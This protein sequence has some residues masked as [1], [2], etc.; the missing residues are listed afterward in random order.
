MQNVRRYAVLA[1]V[2]LLAACGDDKKSGT[3]PD[4]D[5]LDGTFSATLSGDI[6]GALSGV[7][8]HAAVSSGEDQGFVMAFE[9]TPTAG[10]PTAS[11][12]IARENPAMPATGQITLK[13]PE[14][15]TFGPN[16]YAMLAVVTD[17][18]GH[19]W[20]CGSTGGSLTITASSA[21]RIRG[22]M[23]I[24]ASC[25]VDA[26]TEKEI[27]LVGNFDSRQETVPTLRAQIVAK[28]Y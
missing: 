6:T 24:T 13:N 1:M 4:G 12:L 22:S 7:A 17:A 2:A 11:I 15:D 5:G 10:T 3:G 18:A 21:A 19:D 27:T 25:F 16:D 9:D 20:L 23:N 28:G 14:D 8:G 26:E